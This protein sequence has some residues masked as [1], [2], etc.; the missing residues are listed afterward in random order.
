MANDATAV[1]NWFDRGGWAYAR[2]RP[3]YPDALARFLAELS[4]ARERAVD[5]GCGNGQ[6]AVQ[7]ATHFGEVVG[8]DPSTDQ[9]ANSTAHEHVRYICAPAENIPLPDHCVDLVTA[10]QAVHW[11]DLPRF[12]DE[13]R[14]IGRK[15]VVVALIS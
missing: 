10:A 8:L 7:L 9:I 1:K 15:D 13:V 2:F 11:F 4:T 5:V 3:E 14:R 12:Y 6:L